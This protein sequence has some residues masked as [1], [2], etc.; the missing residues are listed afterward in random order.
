VELRWKLDLT[1]EE[2]GRPFLVSKRFTLTLNEK[3]NLRPK[4][5][6]MPASQP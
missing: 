3:G 5:D 4:G 2:T 1:N 6:P